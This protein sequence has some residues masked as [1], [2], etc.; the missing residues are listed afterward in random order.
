MKDFQALIHIWFKKETFSD[1]TKK[2]LD[3]MSGSCHLDA[4]MTNLVLNVCFDFSAKMKTR[5][6]SITNH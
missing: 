3:L 5:S 6:E 2:S 1:G 4:P